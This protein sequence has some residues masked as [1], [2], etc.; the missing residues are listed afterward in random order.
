LQV[1]LAH[2]LLGLSE[3]NTPLPSFQL[4]K[5][6]T[7]NGKMD[8]MAKFNFSAA[9]EIEN[10]HFFFLFP[11]TV[12]QTKCALTLPAVS[13]RLCLW[14]WPKSRTPV[15]GNEMRKSGSGEMKK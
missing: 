1:G 8:V 4:A 7:E 9:K 3:I 15:P 10:Y 11:E 12:D 6:N 13:E 14:G 2:P 5:L